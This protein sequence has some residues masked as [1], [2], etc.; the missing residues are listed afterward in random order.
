MALISPSPLPFLLF[1]KGI[2]FLARQVK[3]DNSVSVPFITKKVKN[4]LHVIP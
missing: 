3:S 4:A 1:L 2:L